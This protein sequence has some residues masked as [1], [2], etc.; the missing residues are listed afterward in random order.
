MDFILMRQCG[1][2]TLVRFFI[3]FV[4]EA[5]EKILL[6]FLLRTQAIV[7]VKEATEKLILLL[8]LRTQAN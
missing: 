6:L 1:L 5:T 8:L 7:F 3:V 2:F 4:R